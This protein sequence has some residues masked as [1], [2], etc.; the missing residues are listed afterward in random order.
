MKVGVFLGS[1]RDG[2]TGE[3]VAAWALDELAVRGDGNSYELIDLKDHPLAPGTA[4]PPREVENGEY[5][6]S[7]TRAW[8]QLIGG[9]DAFIFVTPEYNA[10][11]PGP[12]KSAF[13]LLFGEWTGKP[14]GFV[15][16]GADGAATARKHWVEIVTSI[17]MKPVEAQVGFTFQEHF[18]EFNFT[19]GEAGAATL[20]ALADELTSGAK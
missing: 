12:M 1:V 13:D 11:I 6:D 15:G 3:A 19:P 16:Y 17:G 20:G 4:I 10:S 5:A 9:Y 18:P 8:A 7:D 14:V 2:R